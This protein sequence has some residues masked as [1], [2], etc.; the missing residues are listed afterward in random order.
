[1]LQ[2]NYVDGQQVIVN[3]SGITDTYTI[4]QKRNQKASLVEQYTRIAAQISAIDAEIVLMKAS[5][6]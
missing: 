1:M 5:I 2:T 6:E 3:P 4:A